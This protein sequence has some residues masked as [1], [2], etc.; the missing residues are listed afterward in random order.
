[1]QLVKA[2][3]NVAV[4]VGD[5]TTALVH[6][7]TPDPATLAAYICGYCA[8][9]ESLTVT[10]VRVPDDNDKAAKKS[11]FAGAAANETVVGPGVHAGDC[12]SDGFAALAVLAHARKNPRTKAVI[13]KRRITFSP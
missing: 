1:M 11:T 5:P 2:Y 10:P 12:A 7:A 6:P 9:F 4:E 3:E 13:P 8:L